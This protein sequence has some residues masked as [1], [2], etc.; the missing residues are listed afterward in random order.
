MFT[1]QK[2]ETKHAMYYG[3]RSMREEDRAKPIKI[4]LLVK[5]SALM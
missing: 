4:H 5:V 2:N 3:K 1:Y